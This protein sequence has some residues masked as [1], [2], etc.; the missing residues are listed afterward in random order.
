M[1]K[2]NFKNIKKPLFIFIVLI[3]TS[4][5]VPYLLPST[6][7]GS[8]LLWIILPVITILYGLIVLGGIK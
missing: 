2:I 6:F 5:T 1:I 8:Y 7:T 4:L 3:L